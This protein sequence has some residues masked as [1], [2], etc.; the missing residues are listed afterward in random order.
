VQPA[1]IAVSAACLVAAWALLR[2]GV[3]WVPAYV[4]LGVASCL[5][6]AAASVSPTI[7]AVIFGMLMP[8]APWRGPGSPDADE[9]TIATI[10]ERSGGNPLFLE[11]LAVLV[12]EGGDVRALPDSLRAVIAARLDQLPPDQRAVIDNAAVLGPSGIIASLERFAHELGQ[13]LDPAVLD[14]HGPVGRRA[15]GPA[16]HGAH[17]A[18][19]QDLVGA[20]HAVGTGVPHVVVRHRRHG[21]PDPP[22]GVPP[23]APQKGR[24]AHASFRCRRCDQFG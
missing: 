10:Y 20:G 1:W 18:L 13:R 19:L 22:H 7:D 24:S 17:P 5:A 21:E 14:D 8:M 12:A 23:S 4:V 16:A 3:R 2:A 11:E 15:V 9:S 6:M